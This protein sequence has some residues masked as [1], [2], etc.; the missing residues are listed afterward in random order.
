MWHVTIAGD[1]TLFGRAYGEQVQKWS[2]QSTTQRLH[3]REKAR[4]GAGRTAREETTG[5]R[6]VG[7]RALG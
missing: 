6:V 7:S 3:R 1:I 2:G 4:P 5:T